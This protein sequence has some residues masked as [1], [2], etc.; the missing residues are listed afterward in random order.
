M[1]CMK[2]WITLAWLG[3]VLFMFSYLVNESSSSLCLVFIFKQVELNTKWL[4]DSVLIK[5][6]V[7]AHG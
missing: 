2:L 1:S 5:I 6:Q 3:K 7:K 4:I